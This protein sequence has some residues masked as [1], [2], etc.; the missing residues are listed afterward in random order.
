[1]FKSFAKVISQ[2]EHPLII[3]IDDWQ[4]ADSASLELLKVMM[5]DQTNQYFMIVG[6][7]RDNEVS[8]SHPFMLTLDAIK[9]AN[10]ALTT[11]IIQALNK[12]HV[13]ELVKDAMLGSHHYEELAELVY[14]KTLGNAFFT[15]EFLKSLYEEGLLTF[16]YPIISNQGELHAGGWKWD[17]NQIRKRDITDNVVDL[18]SQKIEKLSSDSKEVITL[19][20]CIDNRFDI[21]ILSII[22]GRSIAETFAP[23]W[24]LMNEGLLL[25]LNEDYK[26]IKNDIVDA[27][28]N[29]SFRFLHDRVQQAAYLLI[30]ENERPR[31]VVRQKSSKKSN[32]SQQHHHEHIPELPK[33]QKIN[34]NCNSPNSF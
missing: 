29:A 13:F 23:L 16:Q 17:L 8:K 18:M 9:E 12:N 24:V 6:A 22:Y 5:G 31:N 1:V 34:Q 2:K 32:K 21:G 7:Y 11:I 26:L 4:W 3:F 33:H 15:V 28:E 19:A 25:P 30:D 14:S 20:A 27:G 10:A